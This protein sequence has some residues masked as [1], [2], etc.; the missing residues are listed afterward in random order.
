M[1]LQFKHEC[2][3]WTHAPH[4]YELEVM[5]FAIALMGFCL[6]TLVGTE[7]LVHTENVIQH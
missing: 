3:W 1:L 2:R 4:Q 6:M 5:N 7:M